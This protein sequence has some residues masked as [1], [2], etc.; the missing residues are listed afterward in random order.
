MKKLAALCVAGAL[1]LSGCGTSSNEKTFTVGME[2]AY[3]PY[4]W[5]TSK[6]TSSSTQLDGGAGY[7][8]GYD[9]WMSQKI[10]EKLGRKLVI[11]KISWDG[12]QPALQ[13]GEIDAIVAGMTANKDREKG[14]DFTTPYYSS[15]MVMIVRKDSTESKFNDIQQFSGYKIMGQ[16]NTNYDTIIDQI[17]GVKHLTPRATYPELVVALQA[18]EADGI[19]AE[20][21][22]ANGIV[23]ANKDLTY[24]TF[25][26]G[27]TFNVDTSVSIGLKEGTRNSEEFKKIQEALNSI[28]QSERL[29]LMEKAVSSAPTGN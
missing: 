23:K 24:V 6:A 26:K 9:V 10:A 28:S 1:L 16:K 20:L 17:K 13:S 7:A 11:K 2:A 22:V 5:Q 8:D 21:P 25:K 27:H 12:L 15:D 19:T 29:K 14:I 3:A 18:K 4:N